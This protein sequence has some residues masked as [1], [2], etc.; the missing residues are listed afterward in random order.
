MSDK[1]FIDR[2]VI[3][4]MSIETL[5]ALLLDDLDNA[6]GILDDDTRLCAAQTLA[7]REKE[8]GTKI[9]DVSSA[10][11]EFRQEYLPYAK[12]GVSLYGDASD[13]ADNIVRLPKKRR[14]LLRLAA[15]IAAA[16]ILGTVSVGAM[17]FDI[18]NAL[19]EWT[20]EEFTFS[21]PAARRNTVEYPQQFVQLKELFEKAGYDPYG[22][23]PSYVTEGYEND[24]TQYWDNDIGELFCCA[25]Y[26][27]ED[28]IVLS[29]Y[30][31]EPDSERAVYSKD[32]GAPE[33]YVRNG[34]TH[35]IMTNCGKY[36]AVWVADNNVE[37]C[38]SGI[39]SHDE[40]I[41]IVDSV[42]SEVG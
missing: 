29:Y 25:L 16:V 1:K 21:N 42:Y 24:E 13:C 8:V 19:D 17:N 26:N 4:S 22:M 9:P 36:L 40:I 20:D 35:Y 5:R 6:G 39:K 33:E 32:A 2:S 41:K 27:G 7:R 10:F 18:W 30:S 31:Y 3:E 37:C 34:I 12:T 14:T 23:L 28:Y 15:A 11:E 38:V